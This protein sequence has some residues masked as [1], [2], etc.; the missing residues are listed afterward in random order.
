MLTLEKRRR[1]ESMLTFTRPMLAASLLSSKVEH[2]DENILAAMNKLRYPVLATLK[3]DGIRALRMN[4]TLLSRTLKPIPNKS[5]RER[6]LV[7]PGGFDMELWNPTLPYDKIESIVMSREHKDS[8]MIQ[9]HVL[10]WFGKEGGYFQ[11]LEQIEYFFHVNEF[12]RTWYKGH[13][14]VDMGIAFKAES[15]EKLFWY[16]T[17]SE[18]C[19]SEG[20]CFRT[21]D[22]P[23][24]M[25]RSTIKEQ[26]LIKLARF[27]RTELTIIDFEE[28]QENTNPDKYNDVGY[29][30]RSSYGEGMIGKNTLGAFI[31]KDKDG[32]IVRV[33]TGVGLTDKL[34]QEIWDNRDSWVGKQITVKYKPHGM[35]DK[36]RS[37]IYVGPRTKGY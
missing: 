27:V 29:M 18:L 10:D 7:L 9:F 34:R 36:L 19:E 5:I 23:Y 12:D 22:S 17:Q 33:G 14:D 32:Q 37:P 30:K 26:Y 24:K 3:K 2:T 28:Q 6:S 15:P 35:K 1:N 8:D 13:P 20:I 31:C 4:G 11:R 16:F 25:G 21:P